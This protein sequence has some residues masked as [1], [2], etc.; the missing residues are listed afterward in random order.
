MASVVDLDDALD[1]A[2]IPVAGGDLLSAL[3]QIGAQRLVQPPTSGTPLSH[4]EAAILAQHSGI[5]PDYGAPI[6]ARARTAAETAL[7][8]TDALTT[9]QI[10]EA[11]RRSPSRVRH[12][13]KE[14]RLYTMPVDRRSGLRFPA[15]QFTETGQPLPGLG[16]V[17]TV[18]PDGLH[19]LQV[20][21]FFTTPTMELSLDDETPL[22]P[23]QWLSEGG[24]VTAVA[25][26]ASTVGEI[27]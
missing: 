12:L 9:N 3:A 8:Y 1:R 19:P 21:G 10:A 15:W 13:A 5:T 24:D 23:L 6:R 18:L 4:G 7:Q 22:S 16:A 25:T 14:R 2:G 27:P 11:T 17:L 26:L 20:A